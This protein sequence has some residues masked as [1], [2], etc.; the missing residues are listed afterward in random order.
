MCCWAQ[1]MI[2]CLL[3]LSLCCPCVRHLRGSP[4]PQDRP[5]STRL[6]YLRV[7]AVASQSRWVQRP[8][9]QGHD[10]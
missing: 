9:A 10:C 5:P 4:F 1:A 6:A 3:E 2:T 8:A 7:S